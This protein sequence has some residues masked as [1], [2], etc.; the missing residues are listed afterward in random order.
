MVEDTYVAEQLGEAAKIINEEAQSMYEVFGNDEKIDFGISSTGSAYSGDH[1]IYLTPE[2][3]AMLQNHG[4]DVTPG[5]SMTPSDAMTAAGEAGEAAASELSDLSLSDL[6][7]K[8]DLRTVVHSAAIA[9]RLIDHWKAYEAKHGILPADDMNS[10]QAPG[11]ASG[12]TTSDQVDDAVLSFGST[13]V[14]ASA[15]DGSL[16]DWPGAVAIARPS[17]D[18]LGEAFSTAQQEVVSDLTSKASVG[19]EGSVDVPQS[20]V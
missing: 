6:T 5:S 19:E 20:T 11:S 18:K 16:G 7:S 15:K 9:D 1:T 14:S 3:Y 2:Q 17:A 4:I 12:D 13:C 10:D 8:L